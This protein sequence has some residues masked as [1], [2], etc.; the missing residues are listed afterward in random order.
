MT[1]ASRRPI[2][3]LVTSRARLA[4]RAGL[5][6]N[7]LESVEPHLLSQIE[8]AAAVGVPLI[9]LREP[10]LDT[11]SL[12]RLARA[13]MAVV[14]GSS[15]RLVVNGRPDV[16]LVAG[17]DG[18]HLPE[19]GLPASAV[20]T[21]LPRPAIIGSS[22]HD[23]ARLEA[24]ALDYAV[25]GTVYRTSSKVAGHSVAG[26]EGLRRA[27]VDAAVPLLAIGGVTPERFAEIAAAGA[28]GFAAIGLFLP[29]AGESSITYLRK[30]LE[31]ACEAFDTV[32]DVF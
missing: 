18:V 30:I 10:D 19:R 8:E 1:L 6:R 13:A 26:L 3:M 11:R 20:R 21:L 12:N 5:R 15:T 29:R 24:A 32:N 27:V 22:V 4:E 28:A 31:S 14:R 25:F 2:V 23:A 17:T 16:A 7:D 9:Q